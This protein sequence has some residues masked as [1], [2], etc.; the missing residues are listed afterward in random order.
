[1]ADRHDRYGNLVGVGSHPQCPRVLEKVRSARPF[2]AYGPVDSR[3]DRVVFGRAERRLADLEPRAAQIAHMI[4]ARSGE[5]VVQLDE[6]RVVLERNRH[7]AG[8]GRLGKRVVHPVVERGPLQHVAHDD[9]LDPKHQTLA[10]GSA[11]TGHRVGLEAHRDVL[12]ADHQ[13][14]QMIHHG[15][16]L[17]RGSLDLGPAPAL[18][19]LEEMKRNVAVFQRN[20]LVHIAALL[21]L[22]LQTAVGRTNLPYAPQ[23]RA[24]RG[25][26]YRNNQFFHRS[27]GLSYSSKW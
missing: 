16:Q 6:R 22:R 18:D 4:V 24:K 1:M 13:L 27:F 15:N 19:P 8:N 7:D 21:E 25:E 11:D 20:R 3:Q 26:S 23:T 12:I 2:V 14:A 10:F 5:V 17:A 9:R